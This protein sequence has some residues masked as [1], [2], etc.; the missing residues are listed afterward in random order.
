M[1]LLSFK[2]T[3]F[4]A[5]IFSLFF[6]APVQASSVGQLV[7]SEPRRI[8]V[9]RGMLPGVAVLDLRNL[10][11]DSLEGLKNIPGIEKVTR[12]Y[13]SNN[14]IT[15]LKAGDLAPAINLRVLGLSDNGLETIEPNAFAGLK[16]LKVLNLANNNIVA[17]PK[18][19]LNGIQDLRFLGMSQNPMSNPKELQPQVPK[20]LITVLPITRANL[21]KWSA[22]VGAGV[23]ALI[24]TV[25]VGTTL[26]KEKRRRGLENI[27]VPIDPSVV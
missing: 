26:V 19:G 1:K 4:L 13:L 12:L 10:N 15:R 7:R 16:K 8:K 2:N 5:V 22:W 3:I 9:Q 6:A 25:A 14:N 17:I 24:G 21:K 18:D 23:A 11:I 20:A 27:P